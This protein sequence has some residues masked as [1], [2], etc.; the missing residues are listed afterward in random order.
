MGVGIV[1]I[2]QHLRQRPKLLVLLRVKRDQSK[3]VYG[4]QTNTTEK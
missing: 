4:G 1:S 2:T 3:S